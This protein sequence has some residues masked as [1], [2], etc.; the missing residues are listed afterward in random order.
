VSASASFSLSAANRGYSLFVFIADDRN[1]GCRLIASYMFG[2][3]KVDSLADCKFY[4]RP[5]E[6]IVNLT[7]MR[8]VKKLS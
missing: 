8:L 4:V 1:S 6:D 5:C 3:L 2:Q 7:W